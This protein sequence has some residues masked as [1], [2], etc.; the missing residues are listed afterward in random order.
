[1]IHTYEKQKSGK[2]KEKKRK[3]FSKVNLLQELPD[4]EYYDLFDNHAQFLNFAISFLQMKKSSQDQLEQY[5]EEER[6]T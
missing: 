1:M 6:T 3:N 4:I 5:L 2:R